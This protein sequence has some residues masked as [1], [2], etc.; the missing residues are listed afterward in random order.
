MQPVTA[1]RGSLSCLA[2]VLQKDPGIQEDPDESPVVQLD[3]LG[4]ARVLVTATSSYLPDGQNQGGNSNGNEDGDEDGCSQVM[5][6]RIVPLED[7]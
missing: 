4:I 5:L 3:A 7:R 6:S 1:R 2:R